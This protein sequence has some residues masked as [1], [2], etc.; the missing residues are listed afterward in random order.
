MNKPTRLIA[1]FDAGDV[2]SGHLRHPIVCGF[3]PI[4][5]VHQ[6]ANL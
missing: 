1:C 2:Q 4:T 3:C 5:L 6:P